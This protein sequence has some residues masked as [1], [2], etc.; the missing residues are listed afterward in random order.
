MLLGSFRRRLT[1]I[2]AGMRRA[3]AAHLRTRPPSVVHATGTGADLL[4]SRAQLLAKNALLRQQLVVLRRS[5]KRPVMRMSAHM[6]AC[7][8]EVGLILCG[9]A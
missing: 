6:P 4:R 1:T 2:V 8:S 9:P 3:L 5:E 7:A